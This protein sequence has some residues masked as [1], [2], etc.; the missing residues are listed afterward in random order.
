MLE[1]GSN[2]KKTVPA[3]DFPA[4]QADWSESKG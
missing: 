3:K 1:Q 4:Y 2:K